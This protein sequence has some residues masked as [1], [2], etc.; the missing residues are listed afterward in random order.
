MAARTSGRFGQTRRW[1]GDPRGMSVIAGV[2]RAKLTYLEPEA[3]FDLR[4]RVREIESDG[5][6]GSL[7]EA[8]CALGGSAI[9]LAASKA[10]RR[11]LYVYDVFGLIPPPSSRDGEDVQRRFAEII[12][13]QSEG[14]DGDPYYGYQADLIRQVRSN[15]A[16]FRLPLDENGIQLVQGLFDDT[17]HPSQPVALAHIDGDWYASVKVCLERVWPVL[18]PGGAVILDDYHAW[19]GCRDATDE[20]AATRNDVSREERSRLHLVKTA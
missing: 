20:F 5:I 15:F 2:R 17:L 16:R 4:K 12:A 11:P 6:P 18:A 10:V 19:S 3:L 9:V 7:I 1:L 14:I 13:G 8:G